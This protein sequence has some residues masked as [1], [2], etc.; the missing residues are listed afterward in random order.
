VF[1]GFGVG[2]PPPPPRGGFYQRFWGALF[3]CM[4]RHLFRIECLPNIVTAR[5]MTRQYVAALLA[6]KERNFDISIIGHAIGFKRAIVPVTKHFSGTSS[7]SF[8]KLVRYFEDYVTAGTTAPLRWIIAAGGFC[9]L[10]AFMFIM[11]SLADIVLHGE[12]IGYRKLVLESIWLLGGGIMV[13]LGIVGI[14]VANIFHQV[15][16]RPVTVVRNIWPAHASMGHDGILYA[17]APAV[18]TANVMP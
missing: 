10:I 16:Q 1:L 5:L 3:Y 4:V 12:P 7:Y 17:D 18:F 14:Y 9:L 2:A 8:L 15:K 11:G 6:H 13:S